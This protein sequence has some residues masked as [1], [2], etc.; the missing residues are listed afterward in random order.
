MAA[1]RPAAVLEECFFAPCTPEKL[2]LEGM[3]GGLCRDYVATSEMPAPQVEGVPVVV[4]ETGAF[5]PYHGGH[6]PST[7]LSGRHSDRHLRIVVQV[8]AIQ[9]HCHRPGNR[10]PVL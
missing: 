5:A 9:R 7:F 3:D 8:G 10:E 4:L 6:G 2:A 1:R